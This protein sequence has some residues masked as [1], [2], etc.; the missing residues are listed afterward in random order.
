MDVSE[1][2]VEWKTLGLSPSLCMIQKVM[3]GVVDPVF[4][5][6]LDVPFP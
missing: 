6:P 3:L 1:G 2:K 4:T 5:L